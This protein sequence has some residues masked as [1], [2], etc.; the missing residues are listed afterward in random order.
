LFGSRTFASTSGSKL[1]HY[2]Q[3]EFS[4]IPNGVRVAS[5]YAEGETATVGVWIDTGSRY[6]A[7]QNNGVAH[8]LE[9]LLFKGTTKRTRASLELE[10][11]N[12]GAHLNAYT[13]REQTVFYMK[14]FKK[15]VAQGMDILADILQ[16]SELTSES[17]ERE[18]NV[19][20]R[21]MEEVN[22]QMEEVIFDRLH[23]TAYR[24][25]ALG[26]TILG[27]SENIRNINRQQI[28][29]YISSH[30][31]GD[32]MVVAG[33]GAVDHGELVKLSERLFGN[34][35]AQAPEGKQPYLEPAR[36]VGSDFRLRDDDMPLAHVAL[37]FPTAGWC[38]PD[39]STLIVMQS[40]LGGWERNVTAG[41]GV[42]SSSPLVSA[43]ASE[44]VALSVMSFNTQY[45]D[46]GLFG[47]YAT[48]H[49]VGLS[50]T[51]HHMATNITRLCYE[52]DEN[53][54]E[55]TKNQ[56]K[57]S[58]FSHLDGSSTICEDIGR[59][60]LTFGRRMHPSEVVARIEAVD[61]AAVKDCANRYFYDRD[62]ALAAIGPLN[63]LQDYNAIRRQS[64]W[65]WN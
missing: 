47:L 9:H 32:R 48:S 6:E 12:M 43:L 35:P 20:L 58:V 62:H 63:E 38:D 45:S 55:E 11:E 17:I 10:I 41:S 7:P 8:F 39:A 22:K 50:A 65:L 37:A 60:M 46:T 56:L 34:I 18:R 16:N 14:V 40:L 3:T 54:L 23:E 24:D 13:S 27:P 4:T 42:H 25:C 19:I 1:V 2:P 53:H 26:R 57:M 31:T 21:E 33:A 30:Y 61:A 28:T 59:Q 51:M 5:E 15:D 36:F 44:D 52:V 29:D 64:H 49:P